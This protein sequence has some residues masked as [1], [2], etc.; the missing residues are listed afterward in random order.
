[1]GKSQISSREEG[2]S[3]YR[4]VNLEMIDKYESEL[5]E[6][7]YRRARH[8]VSETQRVRDAVKAIVSNDLEGL[9]RL[10]SESHASLRDNFMVSCRSSISSS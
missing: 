7:P 6:L 5:A 8:V 10:I 3:S 9:G 2:V 4:D 1:M